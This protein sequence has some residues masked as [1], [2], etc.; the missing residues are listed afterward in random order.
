MAIG[1]AQIL[2]ISLPENFNKPY[3][4][5]SVTD[6]WNRWHLSLSR[7]LKDY[8]YIPLGGNRKGY[9]RTLFNILAIFVVSGLWHGTGLQYL[10][11]G[12]YHGFWIMTERIL[13]Q[14]FRPFPKYIA[15][16]F[17]F[18]IIMLSW[19][20]FRSPS[21]HYAFKYL[22]VLVPIHDVFALPTQVA[23]VLDASKIS[24]LI[25]ALFIIFVI[26]AVP[27]RFPK[28]YK[29]IQPILMG[30]TGILVF[31]YALSVIS[32]SSFTPFLYFQY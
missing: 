25:I 8:I 11:W 18:F 6:F 17:T 27:F 16:P 12:L 22:L 29:V 9:K 13:S 2:G 10:I 4:S 21:W 3:L 19:V 5:I 24:L 7:F 23:V 31:I 20:F 30:T 32:T 1:I 26:E 15:I 28:Q 14:R